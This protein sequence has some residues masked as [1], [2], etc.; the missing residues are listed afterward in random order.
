MYGH[1]AANQ[2]SLTQNF[3]KFKIE[4][5]NILNAV[6]EDHNMIKQELFISR[7][8]KHES[9]VKLASIEKELAN[10]SSKISSL[11]TTPTEGSRVSETA[12]AKPK[13]SVPMPEAKKTAKVKMCLIGDS[14][15]KNMDI[16][17][18][19]K[20]TQSKVTIARAYSSMD[21]DK[22]N[23]VKERT[24]FPN[25]N[26]ATVI[27]SEMKNS[28]MDVLIIQAGSV[29][30]T[31]LKTTDDNLKNYSEYFKQETVLSATNLFTAVTNALISNPGLQKTI[32]MKQ[33]PRFD[34]KDKDPHSVK[35]AL[36]LLFNDTLVQLWLGSPHK[37]RILIGNHSLDCVGAV[38]DAR[39]RNKNQYDGIHMMGVSG[40]KA[41]TE[42]VLSIIRDADLIRSP[43]PSYFRRYH[44]K[45]RDHTKPSA[46]GQSTMSDR[47]I[48]NNK[49]GM[50]K[51]NTRY[52]VPT[53]TSFTTPNNPLN[54]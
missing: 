2:D 43:P 3:E 23:E 33:I 32:I 22:E 40:L 53:S 21:D 14:I 47:D 29:D 39:Y 50:P 19:E 46:Q 36:S 18:L 51:Q 48:R 44:S 24:R 38:R 41:Y 16:Q 54:Y 28:P 4:L 52:S 35:S 31:N 45:P 8:N 26:F 42:S 25:K 17:I 12:S 7:Q 15:S 5:T 20:A 27:E 30:V 49:K 10:I 37:N 6:I 9:D 13:P 1:I 11:P 34:P